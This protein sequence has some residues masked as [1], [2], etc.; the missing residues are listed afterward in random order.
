[1]HRDKGLVRRGNLIREKVMLM[2]ERELWGR[3]PH[4]TRSRR[5]KGIKK[6]FYIALAYYYKNVVRDKESHHVPMSPF[7]QNTTD[8][9]WKVDTHFQVL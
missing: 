7:L 3:L 8:L 1:M 9:S 2:V 4:L 6:L 5:S